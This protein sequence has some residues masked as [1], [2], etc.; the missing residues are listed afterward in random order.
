MELPGRFSVMSVPPG[1]RL[2]GSRALGGRPGAM[3]AR[4]A[5]GHHDRTARRLRKRARV[6]CLMIFH[7]CR[8]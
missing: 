8:G 7:T 4:A 6:Q 2:E 5:A 1:E 3:V